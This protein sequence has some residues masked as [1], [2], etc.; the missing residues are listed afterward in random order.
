MKYFQKY[1]IALDYTVGDEVV[2]EWSGQSFVLGSNGLQGAQI[3]HIDAKKMGGSKLRDG[4]CNLM[5]LTTELH[6]E[7]GDKTAHKQ[8]LYD[9]HFEFL[10][11]N[12]TK[13][14]WEMVKK[15]F[16][17]GCPYANEFLNLTEGQIDKLFYGN[18]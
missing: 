16:E 9:R 2:C 11:N 13:K 5:C 17:N 6:D 8:A 18:E 12:L 14:G 3:H 4:I 15:D 10:R 1:F 7:L